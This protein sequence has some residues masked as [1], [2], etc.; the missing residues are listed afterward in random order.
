GRDKPSLSVWPSHVIPQG[1]NVTFRCYCHGDYYIFKFYKEHGDPIPQIHGKT[2]SRKLDLGPVTPAYAGA[3]RCYCVNYRYHDANSTNSDPVKIIISGLYKKPSL[4]ALMGPV[5]ISGENMTLSCVSD[6][7]FHMFHLSR[8]GVP[9][10]RGLPAVQSHSGAFHSN[11]HLGP[12]AQAGNY[13]CYG[14][15]KNSSYM[16]ST[17]SDPLYISVTD[18]HSKLHILIGIS[19][20]ERQEVTYLE[21]DQMIFKQNLTTRNSQIPKEFS[22]DPSVYM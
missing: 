5:V 17:P 14:S 6:L 13:S 7:Q 9:Q 3:Y 18:N 8:E 11:F 4:S 20:P 22:T 21:F 15:F 2:F 10:G 1:Q 12:V 19:D 16:W